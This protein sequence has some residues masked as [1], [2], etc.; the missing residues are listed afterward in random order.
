M[1]REKVFHTIGWA[2]RPVPTLETGSNAVAALDRKEF[3]PYS[4]FLLHDMGAGRRDRA[5]DGSRL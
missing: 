4:D 3:H 5:G 2:N 1:G